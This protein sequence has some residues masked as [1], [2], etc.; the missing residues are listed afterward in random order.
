MAFIVSLRLIEF[1]EFEFK[2]ADGFQSMFREILFT[3]KAVLEGIGGR[4]GRGSGGKHGK[5]LG[6]IH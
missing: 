2:L 5:I 3:G 1:D 6:F 4:H